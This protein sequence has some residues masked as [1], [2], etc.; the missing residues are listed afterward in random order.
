MC[1][2]ESFILLPESTGIPVAWSTS[3][4][5]EMIFRNMGAETQAHLIADRLVYRDQSTY[6]QI[7]CTGGD[8]KKWDWDN[9]PRIR[10]YVMPE[11]PVW[12]EVGD[13][14]VSVK[15]VNIEIEEV[16]DLPHWL[17]DNLVTYQNRVERILER[18]NPLRDRQDRLFGFIDAE[19][20]GLSA[21][22]KG[23]PIDIAEDIKNWKDDSPEVKEWE[24][25]INEY[26]KIEGFVY[27]ER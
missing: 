22:K 15:K 12:K 24:A 25:I 1:N 9:T 6:V 4:H 21:S 3:Y 26:R 27:A 14:N 18:L 23:N 16:P 7:E 5:H 2:R 19:Y 20:Y 8:V 10:K 17:E 11:F 13:A